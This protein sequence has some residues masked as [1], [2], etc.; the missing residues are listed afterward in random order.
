MNP[1]EWLYQLSPSPSLLLSIVLLVALCESLAVIGLLV[2]GIVL[3]TAAASLAGHQH[4]SL[5]LLLA[6]AFVGAAVGDGLSFW[7]G[8]RQRERV[9][10]LWPFSRHP[11]WLARGITFFKRYG[12]LSILIGRF[13]GPVRP[14]VPLVAGMM[15]MSTWRFV[16]VNIGSALL[17]APAYLLPGYLLG[18][19]WDR[20]IDLPPSSERW[21]LILAILLA[22]L[23]VGFSWLRHQLG[24]EGRLYRRLAQASRTRPWRRRVWLT[25]SAA[26][27][28]NE[29]PLASLALLIGSLIAL[30]GWTLWVLEH[31]DTSL[32][33][34][35]QLRALLAPLA[36]GWPGDVSAFMALS[37]DALGVTALSLPWLLWLLVARRFAAFFH[38][39]VALGGIGVA[40]T[41]F[42]YLAAR[43]R[44]ETPDYL[45][46]SFSYP[47]AHTSTSVVLLGLTAAFIAEALPG[48]QRLWAYWGAILVCLP[49]ALSRLI[50][51]VHWVSDLIG[52]A[53]L[54]LVVCALTR[55]SYQRFVRAPLTSCPWP[56]LAGASLLLL[57][58]RVIWLPYV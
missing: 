45:V 50:L 18:H 3:L 31:P 23:G 11:E 42:K 30:C 57:T 17:W 34:D 9:P 22:V 48:R 6:A 27:P 15:H 4:L 56:W 12:D 33:M 55:L 36:D 14:I 19:S 7:L 58:I 20:L 51:G 5:P 38:I 2:P 43:P 39:T 47:S 24:R 28:R 8:R 54:G 25:L 29:I 37:G 46:G 52:G 49:M 53:L 21:L 35:R 13:V 10:R 26:H 44:P 16:A 32:P 1:T 41:L 40:N